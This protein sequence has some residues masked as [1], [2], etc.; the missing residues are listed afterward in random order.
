MWRA[1]IT[2]K[3]FNVDI[4]LCCVTSFS[5]K[6]IK[7]FRV[8]TTVTFIRLKSF[9]ILVTYYMFQTFLSL[10][11][12]NFLSAIKSRQYFSCQLLLLILNANCLYMFGYIWRLWFCFHQ[13]L[14]INIWLMIDI[15]NFTQF[16]FWSL[17]NTLTISH[18]WIFWHIHKDIK[19]A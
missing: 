7:F 13:N 19:S 6:Y 1:V 18:H 3:I 16:F 10:F 8:G 15:S 5:V 4:S 2:H 9:M 11:D 17:D 14:F 12:K